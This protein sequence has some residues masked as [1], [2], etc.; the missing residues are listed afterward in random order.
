MSAAGRAPAATRSTSTVLPGPPALVRRQGPRLAGHRRRRQWGGPRPTCASTPS[1]STYADGDT[2]TLPAPARRLRR[3]AGAPGARARRR[4]G[5]RERRP[6]APLRR[7]ARP[8][9]DGC[10]WIDG[11]A[12]DLTVPGL[13]FHRDPS[14]DEL[15]PGGPSIVVGAEQSQHLARLRRHVHPQGVPPGLR[16][17]STPTSRCT[18]ALAAAG[19]TARRRAARLGR[20]AD[21]ATATPTTPRDAAALPASAQPTAGSWRSPASATCFAEADLHA[22]EVGGDFAGEAQR[23]GRGHRRGAPRAGRRAAHRRPR[24]QGARRAGRVDA[25]PAGPAAAEV[26]DL[27]AVRRRRCGRRSTTLAAL[28][29]PV[30]GA[31]RPRRLPPRPGAADRSTAGCCS[32]SRASPPARSPSAGRRSRPLRDVAGHAALLRLR[33]P[34]PAGRPP[35]RPA[36]RVPGREWAGRNRDAFCDGLR[37]APAAPTRGPSRCCCARSRPTRPSTRSSTRP[38]TARPGS[39]SPWQRSAGSPRPRSEQHAH[40]PA[41]RQHAAPAA[42]PALRR[43]QLPRHRSSP[44]PRPARS[45]TRS[46]TASC[47]ARTTTR[48]RSSAPH[49][50]RRRRDVPRAAP[51]RDVGAARHRRRAARHA[52]R[53][54]TA[55]GSASCRRPDVPDY[56]L[57]VAYDG[58]AVA[59]STTPTASCPTLGELDLHLIGE[60]R[61]EELWTVLGAHVRVVRRRRRRP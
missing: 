45:P 52:A 5:R 1:P 59:A 25:D 58:H 2:E 20:G 36:A 30:A 32:T 56:R 57:E 33:G 34:A 17:A 8:G 49:P 29:D 38:A 61:H 12:G 4:G 37:P 11:I 19:C 3:R 42:A 55:S 40:H 50:V 53:V 47:P 16:R 43:R 46:C 26:A 51:V 9:R 54:A 13:S 41:G 27:H 24:G 35:A 21:R 22:D 10:S 44:A 23:L 28:S 31:A 18:P 39:R 15:P 48:T 14:L 60:G 7:P 6:P